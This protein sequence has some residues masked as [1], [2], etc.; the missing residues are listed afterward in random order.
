[1]LTTS[2]VVFCK[3]IELLC[4]YT[5]NSSLEDIRDIQVIQANAIFLII[6]HFSW[7][8]KGYTSL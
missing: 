6:F 8:Y 4:H 2:V 3:L 1:M 5:E 7:N